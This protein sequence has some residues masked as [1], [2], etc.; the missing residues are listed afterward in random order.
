MDAASLVQRI[1]PAAV[2]KYFIW[3]Y[4]FIPRWLYSKAEVG[5]LDKC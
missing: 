1:A 2:K 4:D 5:K 3:G